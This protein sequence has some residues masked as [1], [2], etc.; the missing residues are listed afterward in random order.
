MTLLLS[1]CLSLCVC[2][3]GYDDYNL[4]ELRVYECPLYIIT[5]CVYECPF[6]SFDLDI[7]A[8]VSVCICMCVLEFV[9]TPPWCHDNHCIIQTQAVWLFVV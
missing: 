5:L 9:N 7:F 4:Q 2:G 6:H 8:H 3:C 1:S